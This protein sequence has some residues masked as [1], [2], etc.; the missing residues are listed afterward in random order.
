MSTQEVTS[1]VVGTSTRVHEAVRRSPRLRPSRLVI[2]GVILFALA[3]WLLPTAGMLVNSVRPT[4]EVASS[5]WWTVPFTGGELTLDNYAFVLEREGLLNAFVNSLIIAV[6]ATAIPVALAAF[7]AYAFAWLHFRGRDWLFVVFVALLAVPLQVT[8]VP[9][10]RLFR[11]T[12]MSGQ[13]M[14]VWLAGTGYALP[15]SVYLLR[16]AMAELPREVLESAWIDGAGHG[17]TFLHLILPM[18]APA[19]GALAIFQFLFVWNDLLVTLV[20]LGTSNPQNLPLTVLVANLSNSLGSNWH[21]LMAAAFLT[22]LLPLA[23]FFVFQRSFIRGIT[24]GSVKG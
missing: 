12:G 11:E 2:H 20:I 4:A 21:Y 14:A 22:A 6:P 16:N 17:R 7:A 3:A 24:A 5:G 10:L 15:F 13:F 23:V 19:I 9:I 18:T 8:L 1:T